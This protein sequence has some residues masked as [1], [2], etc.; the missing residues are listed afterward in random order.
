MV[1]MVEILMLELGAVRR[2]GQCS[3]V[4]EADLV[5]DAYGGDGR[6]RGDM[7]GDPSGSG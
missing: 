1:F 4:G 2:G 6:R 7:H 3:I 5:A